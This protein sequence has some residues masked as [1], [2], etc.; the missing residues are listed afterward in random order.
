MD[1]DWIEK[2]EHYVNGTMSGEEQS[3]FEAEL[4]T[5]EEL[6]SV[7]RLFRVIEEKTQRDRKYSEEEALLKSS[8]QKLN[9]KYF[10]TG[11]QV[12]MA[13][14]G[15]NRP[16]HPP[17]TP[18]AEWLTVHESADVPA[19]GKNY[20]RATKTSKWKKLALAAIITGI[21][22]TGTIRFLQTRNDSAAVTFNDR[23]AKGR[24]TI[25]KPDTGFSRTNVPPENT[26]KSDKNSIPQ[27]PG[28]RNTPTLLK[29]PGIN[30]ERREALYAVYSRPDALPGQKADALEEGD[31]SYEK[32]EYKEAIAGYEAVIT[33]MEIKV[34]GQ[35]ENDKRT[36]F[37]AYYYRAQCYLA[38]DSAA[39]AIPD[40]YKAIKN[41]PDSYLTCKVQ[42]YLALALLKTGEVEKASVRLKQVTNNKSGEYRQKATELLRKIEPLEKTSSGK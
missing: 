18:Q 23:K 11:T 35:V 9:K 33:S 22:A 37:Y 32:G 30:R 34:R 39:K 17:A 6:A 40:F 10:I 16:E 31:I 36:V 25:G 29:P 5:N 28:I 41:G 13:Q 12:D 21:A 20:G 15:E 4:A 42:W 14:V 8:L 38:I 3:R 27:Q 1:E 19:A 24:T 26:I 7:F 2:I